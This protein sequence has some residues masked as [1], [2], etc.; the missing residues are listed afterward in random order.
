MSAPWAVPRAI[1]GIDDLPY[2]VGR[3]CVG[4]IAM[5]LLDAIHHQFCWCRPTLLSKSYQWG[6]GEMATPT[7]GVTAG[8]EHQIRFRTGRNTRRIRATVVAAGGVISTSARPSLT[9]ATTTEGATT[10]MQ[11]NDAAAP[12]ADLETGKV[13]VFSA[14]KR[15]TAD[16]VETVTID[17]GS[18]LDT[19]R[20]LAVR[21]EELPQ[22]IID[23][24]D[25]AWAGDP[26][27]FAPG[28]LITD[29]VWDDIP[30]AVAI[31]RR[32]HKHVL[33][34]LG[35]ELA[36]DNVAIGNIE[37]LYTKSGT[38]LLRWRLPDDVQ[39]PEQTTRAVTCRVLARA[40]VVTNG[41]VRFAFAGGA[42]GDIGNITTSYSW[43]S[44]GANIATTGESVSLQGYN[45][46]A[47]TTTV[48]AA[49][50]Q[51]DVEA[52]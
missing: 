2:K 29:I 9:I 36:T 49:L 1:S 6:E 7:R 42:N 47:G 35:D 41:N 46:A 12:G 48:Y 27:V 40:S 4:R 22:S 19:V 13:H 25:S 21:I 50:V 32:Y 10:L 14:V 11:D 39:L 30:A 23:A 26:G 3:P 5:P 15:V 24:T 8:T 33:L 43:Y 51:T 34:P 38:S 52:T 17:Q 18:T 45:T 16:S 31:L 28:R 37:D 44:V 20:I